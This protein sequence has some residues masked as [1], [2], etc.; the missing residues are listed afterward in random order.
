M[1]ISIV[2]GTYNRLP[3]LKKMVFSVKRP[4]L[5]IHGFQYEIVL[6]DGGSTDG[7]QEWCRKQSHIRL[8]EHNELKGAIK[9]F[10]DGAYAATG[11]YVIMANDDIEFVENSILLAYAYM[12]N[13]PD[14]GGGCFYQDRNGRDWHIESMPAVTKD[15]QQV[16]VP[17]A[18]VGIFPK[19][20]GDHVG[21]WCRDEDFAQY[22][23]QRDYK[24]IGDGL[25]GFPVTIQSIR[26]MSS[27]R[28]RIVTT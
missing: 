28:L 24:Q 21:W 16:H 17:Y 10:N 1:D 14:C 11:K 19:W 8:I 22:L 9:A 23:T 18:Q 5:N 7:T 25:T 20:L 26:M 3:Y 4:L 27:H 2:S 15:K 12:E 13:N 6:V